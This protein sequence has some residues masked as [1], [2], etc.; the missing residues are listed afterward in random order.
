L[1]K[2]SSIDQGRTA[3]RV[4]QS[5]HY[6]EAEPV[7]CTPNAAARA[8]HDTL[9]ITGFTFNMDNATFAELAFTGAIRVANT[10]ADYVNVV[11]TNNTIKNGPTVAVGFISKAEFMAWRRAIR[12]TASESPSGCMA[13]ITTRGTL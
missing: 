12:S 10:A 3:R 5:G 4:R 9:T 8:A 1:D 13:T 11:I 2:H 6:R 7:Y